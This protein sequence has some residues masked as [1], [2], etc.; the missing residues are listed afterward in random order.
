MALPLS[1]ST[2]GRSGNTRFM[3]AMKIFHSSVPWKS[4]H[5][6]NPSSKSRRE[7]PN[8]DTTGDP[9]EQG[10]P[11]VNTLRICPCYAYG[12]TAVADQCPEVPVVPEAGGCKT[13]EN[14]V[15]SIS[16]PCRNPA[17][18]VTSANKRNKRGPS[19][20]FRLEE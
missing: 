10:H 14:G 8:R 5:I 20:A 16:V 7:S 4:S 17:A 9:N 11:V 15:I 18:S 13:T 1:M 12:Y 19:G 2:M 3:P 6:K